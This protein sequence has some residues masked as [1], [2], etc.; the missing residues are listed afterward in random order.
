MFCNVVDQINV[1]AIKTVHVGDDEKADKVGANAAGI[2]CWWAFECLVLYFDFHNFL[3]KCLV[4]QKD[5][6]KC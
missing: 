6:A 4:Q 3:S 5:S 2:D 1:E